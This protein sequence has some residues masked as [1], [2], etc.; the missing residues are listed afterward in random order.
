[1]IFVGAGD[2]DNPGQPGLH[3]DRFL[4]DDALIEPVAQALVAGYLAAITARAPLAHQ[5]DR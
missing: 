1:M 2:E 5:P 4:P 3:H